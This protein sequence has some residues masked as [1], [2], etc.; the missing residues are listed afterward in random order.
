MSNANIGSPRPRGR[1][2][3]PRVFSGTRVHIRG[4]TVKRSILAL[5]LGGLI[6]AVPVQGF[7][8]TWASVEETCPVCGKKIALESIASYGSYIYNWAS[9]QQLVFWPDTDNYGVWFCTHCHY[10]ALMGDFAGLPEEA[11][12]RVREAIDAAR[13]EQEGSQYAEIPIL[14]RLRMAQVAYEAR[15]GSTDYF[16][17]RFHRILGYHLDRAGDDEGARAARLE[18]IAVAERMLA[19]DDN[20]TPA[21][22]LLFIIAAMQ[23][24]TG[25][26]GAA[27][28][29][30]DRF[31]EAPMEPLPEGATAED[32]AGYG[33]YLDEVAAELRGQI[34][35]PDGA[36]AA[37]GESTVSGETYD[38]SDS[39]ID[40]DLVQPAGAYLV[41]IIDLGL[42]AAGR[43]GPK[44][45]EQ[46]EVR[47]DKQLQRKNLSAKRR[48][49]LMADMA[50]RSEEGAREVW[51]TEYEEY[52]RQWEAWFE[53]AGAGPEPAEPD[54]TVADERWDRA[55]YWYDRILGE[56]QGEPWRA[57]A[58]A[59]RVR[60]LLH[61]N[62]IEGAAQDAQ[63]LLDQAPDSRHAPWAAVVLGDHHFQQNMLLPAMEA[64]RLAVDREDPVQSCYARYKLAWCQY[65]LGEFDVAVRTL[66]AMVVQARE[67]SPGP[68]DL[69]GD[70]G[71]KDMVIMAVGLPLD[72]SLGAIEAAC[73]SAGEDCRSRLLDRLAR[74]LEEIGRLSDAQE[75]RSRA[76]PAA[77]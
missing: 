58:L 33:G 66:T 74:L 53:G 21:K 59:G 18:A 12:D 75:V 19:A 40:G 73:G 27:R 52:Y 56:P 71:L 67:L 35:P 23:V 77:P 31:A 16:W 6:L 17:C 22:E 9:K 26:D 41:P 48:I 76:A 70:E 14:Y 8:T 68:A 37:A 28:A 32:M 65:N 11:V 62:R 42:P 49:A 3:A 64:Y 51:T 57:D 15:G 46:R 61:A 29:S 39:A 44:S 25:Q 47:V 13:Q 36:P 72:E 5:L 69:L 10:A 34:Q 20:V 30:L 63:L 55:L 54:L 50:R 2:P 1:N 24:F 43:S 38:F 7:S 4:E 45:L 60:V